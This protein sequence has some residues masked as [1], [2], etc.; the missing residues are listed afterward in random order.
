MSTKRKWY[1]VYYNRKREAPQV[2]SIDEGD[3]TSEINVRAVEIKARMTTNSDLSNTDADKPT[4]WIEGYA[5]LTF[6]N[7]LA[8]L[9]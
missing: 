9:S 6:R 1:R 8:I 3:Q 7:G 2:W 5:H 4:V